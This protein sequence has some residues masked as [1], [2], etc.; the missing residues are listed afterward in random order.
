MDDDA[1]DFYSKERWDNWL[2]RV[3][4]ADIDDEEEAS[5]LYLN[6][7]N[8][9]AIAVAKV[10]EAHEGGDIDT[11][12]ADEELGSIRTIV[13]SEPAVDDDDALVLLDAVQTSLV[14]VFAAADRYLAGDEPAEDSPAALVE[15]ATAAE[16]EEAFEEALGHV[17]GVGWHVIDGRELPV[18]AI[19]DL[20]YGLVSEWLGGLDSLQ[21]ALQGPKVVEEE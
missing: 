2:D 11:A 16:R 21:D 17:S 12:R 3:A 18:D 7:Q 9:T 6:L 10:L 14:A 13:L 20:E 19:Q 15:A 1:V 8:D 5:R 4:T